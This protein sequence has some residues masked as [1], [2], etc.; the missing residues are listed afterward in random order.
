ME[1]ILPRSAAAHP[2]PV[3]GPAS[4]GVLRLRELLT[5]R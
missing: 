1:R 5:G 4:E 3:V 2:A